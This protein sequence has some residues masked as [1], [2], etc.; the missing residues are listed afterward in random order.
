MI[1]KLDKEIL[2]ILQENSRISNAEIGR[3]V[4]VTASAI[5]ERIK[6]MEQKKII[7]GFNV[8]I[9]PQAVDLTLLAFVYIAFNEMKHSTCTTDLLGDISNIQELHYIAGEDCLLAKIRCGDTLELADILEDI[10]SIDWVRSTKTTIV[11]KPHK[12]TL[13][14]PLDVSSDV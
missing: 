10:N 7:L 13:N 11:L 12:E 3:R 2:T 1:D 8:R 5:Y 6:K 14:V 9:N 4:G